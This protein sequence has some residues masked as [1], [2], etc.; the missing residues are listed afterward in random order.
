MC[1]QF[2]ISITFNEKLCVP[3]H[4]INTR[5]DTILDI[6]VINATLLYKHGMK[7]D[8]MTI[9][10][11]IDPFGKEL[12][13]LLEKKYYLGESES[14]SLMLMTY[15]ISPSKQANLRAFQPVVSGQSV[16]FKEGRV[17]YYN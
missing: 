3:F 4:N 16:Q 9:N 15:D 2:V 14:I 6:Y 10:T 13:S 17:K 7:K 8:V 1:H 5:L 12:I 11:H